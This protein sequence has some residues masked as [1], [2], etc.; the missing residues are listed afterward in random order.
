MIFSPGDVVMVDVLYSDQSGMK[1]RPAV[2]LT[3]SNS[4]GDFLIAPITS[5]PGLSNAL[6]LGPDRFAKG[7]LPLPSWIR[8]DRV[9]TVNTKTVVK[10]FGVLKP[11]A[12]QDIL[13]ILCPK[14]GC[15]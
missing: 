4:E 13:G 9:Y 15:R 7:G 3:A 10:Q 5:K 14:I 11:P 1:Q 12:V 2:V 8:A 6:A